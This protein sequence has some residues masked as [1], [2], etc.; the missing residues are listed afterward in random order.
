M[1]APMHGLLRE[2]A[3]KVGDTVTR[4]TRL[5]VLEAMKMQHEILSDVDGTVV[6]VFFQADVQVAADSVLIEIEVTEE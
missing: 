3:V 6:E 4:G 1:T 2:L 5:A